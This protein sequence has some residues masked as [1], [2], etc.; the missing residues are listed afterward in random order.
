MCRIIIKDNIY[1]KFG[2]F[3]RVPTPRKEKFTMRHTF[4]RF[5]GLNTVLIIT[6]PVSSYTKGELWSLVSF[7]EIF[8]TGYMAVYKRLFVI[9][10][11]P[12][13]S[14]Y[15]YNSNTHVILSL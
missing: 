10:S 6:V 5:F 15:I 9:K 14:G 4:H 11:L 3:F 13:S 1:S 2:K 7:S 8:P 12:S